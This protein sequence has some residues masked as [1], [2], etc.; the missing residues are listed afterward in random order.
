MLDAGVVVQDYTEIII[1]ATAVVTLAIGGMT[2][3]LRLFVGNQIGSLRIEMGKTFL[4]KEEDRES[5]SAETR[6][7]DGEFA[8]VHK[9]I[10]SLKK[11]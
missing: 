4:T 6:R 9:R 10:D 8:A 2:A 3:Y 11:A 7:V 5:D 1:A